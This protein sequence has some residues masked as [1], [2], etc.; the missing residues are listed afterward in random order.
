[1]SEPWHGIFTIPLTPFTEDLALDFDG[2]DRV[3]DFCVAAGAH[4]IVYPVMASEFFTLSD[5]E[6]MRLMPL[7]TRQV[8]GRIPVVTGVAA[9]TMSA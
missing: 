4:G 6:R 2:L 5:E 8:N 7:V 1:M 9:P 3:I